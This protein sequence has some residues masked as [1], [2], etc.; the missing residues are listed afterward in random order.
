MSEW[1]RVDDDAILPGRACGSCTLCCKLLGIPELG[2][3]KNEWCKYCEIGSGC[4]IY[5]ERPAPCREFLC[6]YLSWE[7]TGEHWFPARSKM[8][9]APEYDGERLVIHV[10]PARPNAWREQPYYSDIKTWAALAAR[11]LR[12]IVV[13]IGNRSIVILPEED[14]DLG[15]V[16]DDERIVIGEV[17]ENGRLRLRAMKIRADDPRLAGAQAGAV[18]GPSNNPF[19]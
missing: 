9:I 7:M 15:F 14:V 10:D 5:D 1:S 6:G 19:G 3:A 18:Y 4:R 8:V 17:V 13:S 12:Q 11:D 2:K 16:Q